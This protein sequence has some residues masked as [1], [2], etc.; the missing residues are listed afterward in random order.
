[1]PLDYFSSFVNP[2][3]LISRNSEHRWMMN[4]E[5]ILSSKKQFYF[6]FT[7]DTIPG[8]ST[9]LYDTDDSRN[10]VL[11]DWVRNLKDKHFWESNDNNYRWIPKTLHLFNY[12]PCSESTPWRSLVGNWLARL[13]CLLVGFGEKCPRQDNQHMC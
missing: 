1:M 7:N 13:V 9:F 10:P 8:V 11:R 6:H 12:I 5:W 3:M 4:D 2:V